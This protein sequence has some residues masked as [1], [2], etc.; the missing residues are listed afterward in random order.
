MLSLYKDNAIKQSQFNKLARY[1]LDHYIGTDK[2]DKNYKR[3]HKV[4]HNLNLST[5][6]FS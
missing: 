3:L 4:A 2:L 5:E 1:V 6:I